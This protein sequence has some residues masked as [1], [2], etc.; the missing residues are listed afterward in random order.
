MSTQINESEFVDRVQAELSR[1]EMVFSR[2]IYIHGIQV[3]F[4]VMPSVRRLVLLE[5]KN[6]EPTQDNIE[7]AA[8][9]ARLIKEISGFPEDWM[10]EAYVVLPRLESSQAT[11]GVISLAGISEMLGKA[12]IKPDKSKLDIWLQVVDPFQVPKRSAF[13]AMPFA[14]EYDDVF[15]V[16][17]AYGGEQAGAVV[18]RTD[19]EPFEGD[20]V[21]RIHELI[22]QSVAVIADL[23]EA[24]P[25]V[26]YEVGYAH[27][28]NKPTIPIC[29]TS[30]EEL[31]FDVHN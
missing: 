20:V 21:S 19:K 15:F 2:E 4:S 30:L 8:T 18:R 10:V 12:W 22:Q 1:A 27:A 7:R 14:E 11:P 29:S 24:K 17:M 3:D 25:N 28:L 6:W 5:L 9:Q 13:A 31:P 16:A 23:S 26:M